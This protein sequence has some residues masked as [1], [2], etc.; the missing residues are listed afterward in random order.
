MYHFKDRN[1]E[2]TIAIIKNFF[3]NRNLNIE[4]INI[5]KSEINTYSCTCVLFFMNYKILE[6]YG[7]GIT[8]ILAQASG[9]AELYER[10]CYFNY[11]VLDY[12]LFYQNIITKQINIKEISFNTLLEDEHTKYLL[13]RTLPE[14]KEKYFQ[15]INNNSKIYGTK[16]QNL[17]NSTEIK[18]KNL[19]LLTFVTGTNGLATG[20]TIEEA[21]VQGLCELY[22]REYLVSFFMNQVI[23]FYKINNNS[24]N[25]K[26]QK[27]IKILNLKDIEVQIFD[28]SYTLNT[29]VVMIMFIN[30]NI[31]QFFY[32]FGAH[33]IFDIALERCFTEIYQNEQFLN[34][35]KSYQGIN[36]FHT[37]LT[38]DIILKSMHSA[39]HSYGYINENMIFNTKEIDIYNQSVFINTSQNNKELLQYLNNLNKKNNQIYYYADISLCQ[40][41]TTV[42]LIQDKLTQTFFINQILNIHN[43]DKKNQYYLY[44]IIQKLFNNFNY[45]FTINSKISLEI[46]KEKIEEIFLLISKMNF[47]YQEDAI[48]FVLEYWLNFT[49]IYSNSFSLKKD[50]NEKYPFYLLLDILYQKKNIQE[51]PIKERHMYDFYKLIE[52][53]YIQQY[54]KEKIQKILSLFYKNKDIILNFELNDMT[55]LWYINKIFI[56]PLYSRYHSQE[57]Y[58]F[59]KI[60]GPDKN[61]KNKENKK[62]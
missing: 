34:Y 18:Y 2:E 25:L 14:L 51:Y 59:I 17:N 24:L 27:Y 38:T 57:Y 52:S 46:L 3:S 4:I 21:L 11:V 6:S 39:K 13:Q 12:P 44:Q 36:T 54:P 61:I 42:Y 32:I 5:K 20:N 10:F 22:E 37:S 23:S 28:C 56:E 62:C 7:K 41:I 29:P 30:K 31:N 26:F 15:I 9:L 58:N 48:N 1:P 53:Y 60:F 33:P 50:N 49:Q 40:D 16:F 43:Y 8:K 45:L 19:Q 47:C 35:I 55:P